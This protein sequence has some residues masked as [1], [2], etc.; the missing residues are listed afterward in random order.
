MQR[1]RMKSE[2]WRNIKDKLQ[3]AF[4]MYA[5]GHPEPVEELAR[6][7]PNLRG[8]I[9][10]LLVSHLEMDTGSLSVA[11]TVEAPEEEGR[12]SFI[13]TQLG[14]YLIIE[15]IGEGGMGEV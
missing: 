13:G 1:A 11:E 6:S 5:C 10:E 3:P 2:D 12:D 15:Q 9:E 7:H 14:P 8:E 4:E